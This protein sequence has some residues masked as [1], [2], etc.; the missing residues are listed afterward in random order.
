LERLNP[1]RFQ[2]VFGSIPAAGYGFV[3]PSQARWRPSGKL[4]FVHDLRLAASQLRV[5]RIGN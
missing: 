5:D 1:Q 2:A 4:H 3:N